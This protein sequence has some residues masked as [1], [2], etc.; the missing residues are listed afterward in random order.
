[1]GMF[2]SEVFRLLCMILLFSQIPRS[3]LASS[4]VSIV[5]PPEHPTPPPQNNPPSG[6]FADKP[7]S[8]PPGRYKGPPGG[9]PSK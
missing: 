5:Q 2:F 9:R 4:P 7:L 3:F 8:P 6:R 1:M